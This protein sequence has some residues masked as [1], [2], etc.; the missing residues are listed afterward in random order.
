VGGEEDLCLIVADRGMDN[1]IFALLPVN[2]G[3]DAVLVT[4][5]ERVN[6][7]QDLVK[8]SAGG[9]RVGNSQTDDFLR[10]DDEHGSDGE[11]NTLGVDVGGILVVQHVIQGSNRTVLV[12]DDGVGDMGWAN[13][14]SKRLDVLDPSVVLFEAIGGEAKKLHATSGKFLRTTSDFAKLGGANGGKVIRVGEE[15]GP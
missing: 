4:E 5:L 13:L 7:P 1:D 15:N 12:G 3:G 14:A 11:G 6:D 9:G 10:V 8:V 2:W